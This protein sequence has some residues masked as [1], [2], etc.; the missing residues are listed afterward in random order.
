L[1]VLNGA[2][3][4][5][6]T[7]R[8]FLLLIPGLFI[9]DAFAYLDPGSGSMIFQAIVGALIGVGIAVKIYWEKLKYKFTSSFARKK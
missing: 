4:H 3:F 8:I 1:T 6:N 5:K 2:F 9:T 7:L